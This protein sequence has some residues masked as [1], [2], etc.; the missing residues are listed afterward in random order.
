M[1]C[2]ITTPLFKYSGIRIPRIGGFRVRAM[3]DS[4]ARCCSVLSRQFRCSFL[5]G[6]QQQMTSKTRLRSA[7]LKRR[8]GRVARTSSPWESNSRP[9]AKMSKCKA[10]RLRCY[11]AKPFVESIGAASPHEDRVTIW[12]TKCE[13]R[14]K[15]LD[16][17]GPP[18]A[19]HADVTGRT[20][21][22]TADVPVGVTLT[23]RRAPLPLAYGMRIT[24][25][26]LGPFLPGLKARPARVLSSM[27]QPVGVEA[28]TCRLLSRCSANSAQEAPA[29]GGRTR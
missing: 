24:G 4:W 26:P 9:P 21:R 22:S 25:G 10:A 11:T 27:K 7:P 5:C 20:A 1:W 15:R 2:A 28:T 17:A 18:Y 14:Y 3:A 8:A 6:S 19:R 16:P 29:M 12:K 23:R 13:R